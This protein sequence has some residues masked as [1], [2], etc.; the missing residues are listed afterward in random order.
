M[1]GREFYTPRKR[2]RARART[3][4]NTGVVVSIY[5]LAVWFITI[6]F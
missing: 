1:E 4:P 2:Q 5:G 6:F 3:L